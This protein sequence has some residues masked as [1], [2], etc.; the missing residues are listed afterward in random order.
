MAK[1]KR[2]KYPKLPNG[3][4]SIKYLGK[5]RRNPYAVHPPTEQFSE[6]GIP[7]TPKALCYV[8]DWTVGFAVLTAYKAGTYYPGMEQ[9]IKPV[10]DSDNMDTDILIERILADYNRSKG[11]E[12]DV[13]EKTFEEVYQDFYE[14]KFERDKSK[15]YSKA[16]RYS[17]QAAF[18]NCSALHKREFRSL[19]HD[20][21]QEVIDNC[22]LGYASLA[23][24][25]NLY[26]HM[27]DYAEIYDLCDKDYAKHV[28]INTP[29][30]T[31]HGVPFTTEDLKT[32][33]KNKQNETVEF[34]LIMIYSGYR[35]SAYKTLKINLKENYF[36]GGV[37]TASG[38]DRI[39]PIH[40]S[41][42]PLVKSRKKRLGKLLPEAVG[43]YRTKM[44]ETLEGL[45]I[46]K[47]T[48]HDARHT[49]SS[50]CEKYKVKENDRKRMLGHSFG[51]D[52]TNRI[53]GH[54]EIED[55]RTE[56]EKIKVCY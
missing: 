12:L 22:S 21:L 48:P 2:K 39:V 9:E 31:E 19:R 45:G 36:Q 25:I 56:I 44:Y 37:K 17:I 35:I 41:I 54:R 28:K 24:I 15:T 52:I 18:R 14:Y 6:D 46:E 32:L 8:E 55:L 30:D 43:D 5:K 27:Y 53:Y 20:D 49:F 3:Y 26:N 40:S 34:L 42:L 10:T 13:P 33:W 38:R 50:L 1:G 29:D 4:G 47:H 11:I 23:L 7:I 16:A 51:G